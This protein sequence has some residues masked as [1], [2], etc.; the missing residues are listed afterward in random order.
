ML[1]GTDFGMYSTV[2]GGKNWVKEMGIPNVVIYKIYSH[3]RDGSIYIFTHGRGVFKSQFKNFIVSVK[4]INGEES[5]IKVGINNPVEDILNIK[6]ETKDLSFNT[7]AYVYNSSGKMVE[8]FS[9]T[10]G[11]KYDV[12]RLG[13]GVYILRVISDNGS[14]TQKFLKL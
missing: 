2:N 5:K 6:L 9:V 1:V 4:H 14:S 13:H 8:S 10:E 11:Q 12:S 3:P 7:I